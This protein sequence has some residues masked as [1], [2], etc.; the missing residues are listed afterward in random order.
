MGVANYYHLLSLIITII[1][2]TLFMS[3]AFNE[4]FVATIMPAIAKNN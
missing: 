2:I 4:H 1:V 3:H